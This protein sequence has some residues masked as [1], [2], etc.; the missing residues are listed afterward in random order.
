MHGQRYDDASTSGA[1]SG[2]Q[3]QIREQQQLALY[4]HCSGHSFNLAVLS[5]VQFLVSGISLTRL[6]V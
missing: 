2:V 5:R 4:T 1:K 6:R 3:T